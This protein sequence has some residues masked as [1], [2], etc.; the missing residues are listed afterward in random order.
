MNGFT[1]VYDSS[2]HVF[3]GFPRGIGAHGLGFGIVGLCGILQNLANFGAGQVGIGIL[4][5][6]NNASD[7]R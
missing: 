2:A 3:C 5:H 6:R 1:S 4:H 7:Q